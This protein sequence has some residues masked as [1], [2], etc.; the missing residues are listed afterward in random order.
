M[1]LQIKICKTFY[2]SVTKSW[3]KQSVSITETDWLTE[4]T[5]SIAAYSEK[6]AKHTNSLGVK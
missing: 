2:N 6:H 4:L 3:K 5:E 1:A